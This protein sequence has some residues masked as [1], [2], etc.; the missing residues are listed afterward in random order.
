MRRLPC[1]LLIAVGLWSLATSRGAAEDQAFRPLFNG[2]DLSGWHAVAGTWIVEDG[3]V[4]GTNT[5]DKPKHG[6][7]FTDK[8]YGDFT[9]RCQFKAVKGNSGLYFRVEKT[10][11]DVGIK[12]FQAEIDAAN[13]VGGLYETSGRGWVVQPRPDEVKKYFKPGEWN[14]MTV[15]AAGGDVTVHVNGVK[16]AELKNDRG[17]RTGLI[18]FQVHGSQDVEVHI[19]DV[20]IQGEPVKE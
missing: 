1:V 3:V 15:S 9:I 7:L 10:P 2:K 13:D 17:A 14:E 19:K 12:G 6:H 11:G 20:M 4:I 18:A 5:A 16:T 8:P